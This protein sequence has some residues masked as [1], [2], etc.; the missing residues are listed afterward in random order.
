MKTKARLLF[1]AT[2]AILLLG[3]ATL[4]GAADLY[5]QSASQTH[6]APNPIA[7][8]AASGATT[9]GINECRWR[10][11]TPQ[12]ISSMTLQLEGTISWVDIGLVRV[13]YSGSTFNPG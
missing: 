4:A 6:I 2:A 7:V 1:L 13:Y 5:Y 3:A 9:V 10:G 11:T 12:D 8:K